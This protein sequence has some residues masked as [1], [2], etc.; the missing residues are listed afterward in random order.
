L[1]VV[2]HLRR[3][4]LKGLSSLKGAKHNRL[5]PV[6]HAL[7]R[8]VAWIA[9]VVVVVVEKLFF[10]FEEKNL[11]LKKQKHMQQRNLIPAVR[12]RKHFAAKPF[13]CKRKPASGICEKKFDSKN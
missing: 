2:E 8:Y 13:L 7:I 10:F 6:H 5:A 9:S 4:L 11:S 12:V 3:V 1:V